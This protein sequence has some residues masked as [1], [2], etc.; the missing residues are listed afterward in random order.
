MHQ[1]VAPDPVQVKVKMT[2]DKLGCMS[3][4]H[5]AMCMLLQLCAVTG[6]D[7]YSKMQACQACAHNIMKSRALF[8]AVHMQLSAQNV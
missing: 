7:S 1:Q 2:K 5:I 6:Q 3:G 4:N 8:S